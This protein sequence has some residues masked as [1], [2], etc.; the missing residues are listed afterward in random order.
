MTF[1]RLL[2][3]LI[4]AL[5]VFTLSTLAPKPASADG[6]QLD[7]SLTTLTPPVLNLDDPAQVISLSGTLT[8]TSTLPISNPVVHFWRLAQPIRSLEQLHALEADP[9][10]GARV[11]DPELIFE[12]DT[13]PDKSEALQPGERADFTLAIPMTR[14]TAGDE[15]LTVANA[16]Y[17]VGVQVK[18]TIAG[19]GRIT[20][21][22]LFFPMTAT[23]A[24]VSSS[25]V[26]SLTATPSW[27][28]DGTF[29]DSSLS[30]ELGQ[31]LEVLLTSAER[32]G[33]QAAIDPALY[34]AV[35]RLTR[36]HTVG[37]DEVDGNGVALRWLQRVDR[38]LDE[39][40]LWRLSYGNPDLARAEETGELQQVLAWSREAQ[41]TAL[42]DLDSVA[43]L[44]GGS[45][46]ALVAK[47]G[48]F[49]TVI[50]R[51]ATGAKPGPPRILGA[52]AA[53]PHPDQSEPPHLANLITEE[54][55]A[56]RPPL[57]VL[58]TVDAANADAELG[59][60]RTHVPPTATPAE[61]LRW[62]PGQ[63]PSAWPKVVE[64]L[65]AAD[66]AAA[67]MADLTSRPTTE[68]SAVA[69]LSATAFSAGFATEADAVAYVEAASTGPVALDKITL[70]AVSS[71][72]MG[73]RTNTFP[74]T[75]TNGLATAVTVGVKF[76]SDS[77]QRI[78]VPDLEAV[79]I[80]PGESVNVTITP[81]ATANGV[82]LVRAQA[83]TQG[84][85]PIGKSITIEITATDFGRVGWIIILLSGAVLLGGTAWRIRAVRRE[86][87]RA[88]A[89]E[90]GDRAS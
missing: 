10:L 64:A 32:P 26:V 4:G 34:E 21:G 13:S 43:I 41:G 65:A 47:L 2:S 63:T 31:S 69:A 77:P 37:G 59:H 14:L 73:S 18:G 80:P 79:T 54:F 50:V 19:Q 39:G 7:I 15:P 8:N 56:A 42:A 75:L 12:V 9:P 70:K 40:R 58:D 29:L 86:R 17:L 74:A 83:V 11:A 5:L 36:S 52:T 61:P 55:L 45:S 57:Y 72:V 33:V 68:E 87:A 82:T 88:S 44:D 76:T 81:E 16:A 6:D 27:L 23:K 24:P 22:E 20:V 78:N 89:K 1:R 3:A 53:D 38:L 84:G 60:W 49:D 46:E 51:N 30:N 67:L 28:P 62:S 90:S 25:A 66:D 71:F 85:V 35:T 48:E